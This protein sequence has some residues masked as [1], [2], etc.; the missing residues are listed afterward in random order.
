[1]DC[2]AVENLFLISPFFSEVIVMTDELNIVGTL[3]SPRRK[4]TSLPIGRDLAQD[5]PSV[6]SREATRVGS[7]E[8][9]RERTDQ[10]RFIPLWI[11]SHISL[12]RRE[13]D[14]PGRDKV[15][16]VEQKAC[17]AP[18]SASQGNKGDSTPCC[19]GFLR[20]GKANRLDTTHPALP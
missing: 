10:A 11:R 13:R 9:V 5:L 20:V 14:P 6:L 1:M 7:S 3:F 15:R 16:G 8:R 2:T 19:L 17:G 12:D 18:R 4:R